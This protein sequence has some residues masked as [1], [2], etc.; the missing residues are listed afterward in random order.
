MRKR[1]ANKRSV[2]MG[3]GFVELS[4][5]GQHGLVVFR[6]IMCWCISS[7]LGFAAKSLVQGLAKSIPQ[8]LRQLA[9]D[10]HS[11]RFNLP[12]LLQGLDR[13]NAQLRRLTQHLGFFNHG[14]PL[15]DAL[16]LGDF[17]ARMR[18]LDGG[19]PLRL[20]ISKR[21]FTQ[22]PTVAPAFRELM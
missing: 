16:G 8:F 10:R 2:G 18:S 1:L 9:L 7:H 3:N 12:A 17:Q 14:T 11:L 19:L 15:R 20:H 13:I 5:S 4:G 21:F 6:Q 22:V